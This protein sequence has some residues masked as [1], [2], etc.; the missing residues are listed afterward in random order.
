MNKILYLIYYPF[1]RFSQTWFGGY[2]VGF[3]CIFTTPI[4]ISVIDFHFEY[5][6]DNEFLGITLGILSF[7]IAGFL[8]VLIH[9]ANVWMSTQN[10]TK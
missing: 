9:N 2:F 7:P 8:F 1:W 4:I 6:G 3:M 5:K 10:K